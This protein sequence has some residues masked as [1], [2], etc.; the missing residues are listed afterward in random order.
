MRRCR[1]G[2]KIGR[3]AEF[4]DLV[5]SKGEDLVDVFKLVWVA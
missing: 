5:S 1:W 2:M 3:I 4:G